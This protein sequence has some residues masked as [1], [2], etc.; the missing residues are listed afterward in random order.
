[1][2]DPLTLAVMN[3]DGVDPGD[4]TA[5]LTRMSANFTSASEAVDGENRANGSVMLRPALADRKSDLATQLAEGMRTG[6]D[7]RC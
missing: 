5:A 2:S 3:A 4:L 1:M 7:R 6:W